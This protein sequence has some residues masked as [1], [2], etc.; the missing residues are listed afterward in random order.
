MP[1]PRAEP[2]V[3]AEWRRPA[4]ADPVVSA[5]V[6]TVKHRLSGRSP[7]KPENTLRPVAVLRAKA[8][9]SRAEVVGVQPP[10]VATGGAE[11]EQLVHVPRCVELSPEDD[12]VAEP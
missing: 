8:D 12:I 7:T 3:G 5:I 6:Q 11:G 4:E 10:P 9:P 2:V 1:P